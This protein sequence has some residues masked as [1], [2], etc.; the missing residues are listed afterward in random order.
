MQM[1]HVLFPGKFSLK[2]FNNSGEEKNISKNRSCMYFLTGYCCGCYE[3]WTHGACNLGGKC[4]RFY[5]LLKACPCKECFKLVYK[6]I[7]YTQIHL[8]H[9][10]KD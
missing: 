5:A 10:Q 7:G 9:I 2:L 1:V 3:N 4:S 8:Q 6:R